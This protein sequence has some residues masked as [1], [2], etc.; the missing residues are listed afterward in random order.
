MTRLSFGEHVLDVACRRLTRAGAP[1]HLPPKSMDLLLYLV[2]NAE[3]Y[4]TKEEL[5]AALWSGVHVGQASLP[6]LI[7]ELRRGLGK[8]GIDLV[9][10]LHGRGYQF[11]GVLRQAAHLSDV[12]ATTAVSLPPDFEDAGS[13]GLLTLWPPG[14]PSLSLPDHGQVRLGRAQECEIFLPYEKV[15]RN[16]AEISRHGPVLVLRDLASTNGTHADGARV[17]DGIVLR[18]GQ[19]LRLGEWLGLLCA[20]NER[21]VPAWLSEVLDAHDWTGRVR[22]L[23][24]RCLE[25]LALRVPDSAISPGSRA[26]LPVST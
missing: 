7:K 8:E 19:L 22:E 14:G 2:S 25:R 13:Y 20:D 6:A 11:G 9:R 4:V 23:E 21:R 3:R 1:V 16:H 26:E 12:N 10:T 17:R 18:R 24:L 5:Q 15:S